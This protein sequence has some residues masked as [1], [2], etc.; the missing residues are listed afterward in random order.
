VLVRQSWEVFLIWSQERFSEFSRKIYIYTIDRAIWFGAMI[1]RRVS[2]KLFRKF[3]IAGI[4]GR[5][6][7]L[8]VARF[9]EQFKY[10]HLWRFRVSIFCCVIWSVLKWEAG[11][12]WIIDWL[13]TKSKSCDTVIDWIPYTYCTSV[14]FEDSAKKL[15]ICKSINAEWKTFLDSKLLRATV[16]FYLDTV[17]VWSLQHHWTFSFHD[18]ND[19]TCGTNPKNANVLRF[20]LVVNRRI[21]YFSVCCPRMWLAICRGYRSSVLM[22]RQRLSPARKFTNVS[23]SSNCEKKAIVT[24]MRCYHMTAGQCY[25]EHDFSIKWTVLYIDKINRWTH[26]G[27][28]RTAVWWTICCT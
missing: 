12:P 21:R 26:E 24:T 11:Q 10:T 4:S 3:S 27:A 15:T 28:W 17:H 2:S 8:T 22:K 5:C 6:K 14:L 20:G 19:I 23:G 16:K 13:R 1:W 18:W 9:A 7:Y 25:A